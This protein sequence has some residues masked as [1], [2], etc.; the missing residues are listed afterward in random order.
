MNE[1]QKKNKIE[2]VQSI[3]LGLLG[4]GL[5]IKIFIPV[6]EYV[7]DIAAVGLVTTLLYKATLEKHTGKAFLYSLLLLLI[8]ILIFTQRMN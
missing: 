5:I 3:F 8:F 2:M 6:F 4:L 7:M 1:E